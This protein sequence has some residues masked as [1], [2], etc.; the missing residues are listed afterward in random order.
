MN[1]GSRFPYA[2]DFVMQDSKQ[3]GSETVFS[4]E[5]MAKN[6]NVTPPAHSHIMTRTSTHYQHD[7]KIQLVSEGL[8]CFGNPTLET[9]KLQDRL[10]TLDVNLF[11]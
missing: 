3:V 4:N 7:S 6:T 1:K 8:T 9:L 10:P 2:F 11:Q 5:E